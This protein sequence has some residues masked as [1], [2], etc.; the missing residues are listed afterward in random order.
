[1]IFFS[2]CA[3]KNIVNEP[4]NFNSDHQALTNKFL[5]KLYRNYGLNSFLSFSTFEVH[6]KDHWDFF[7]AKIFNSPY[8][9]DIIVPYFFDYEN[10]HTLAKVGDE[11]WFFDGAQSFINNKKVNS[12]K[13]KFHLP[14]RHFFFALPFII[15]RFEYKSLMTPVTIDKAIYDRVYFSG[16]DKVSAKH[17]QFIAYINRSTMRLEV[18]FYTI[19]DLGASFHGAA[20]FY[21]YRNVEGILLPYKTIIHFSPFDDKIVHQFQIENLILRQSSLKNFMEFNNE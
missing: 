21:N 14:A 7:P 15:D 20:H 16:S 6:Y 2:S 9:D 5:F 12:H 4:L 13:V 19:R 18:L 1:M 11:T 3:L 8:S 17:D 10:Y